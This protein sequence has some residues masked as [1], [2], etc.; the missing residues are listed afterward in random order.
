MR[1]RKKRWRLLVFVAMGLVIVALLSISSSAWA[2]P[3]QNQ[4]QQNQTV[5]PIKEATGGCQGQQATFTIQFT[6]GEQWTNVVITD[7]I[8]PRLRIDNVTVRCQPAP[9]PPGTTVTGPGINPVVVTIPT[10]P[11]DTEVTI[12]IECYIPWDCPVGTIVNVGIVTFTDSTGTWQYAP[13]ASLT[14]APCFVPEAGS[15]LLLGSGLAG[16]AGYSGL[17]WR[18]RRK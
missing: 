11:T 4:A 13:T 15:L 5:A 3:A 7:N 16:L 2:T 9:C 18:V 12:T 10:L 8:D 14:I 17:R 6:N 1:E